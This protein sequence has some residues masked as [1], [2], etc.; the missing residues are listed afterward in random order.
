MKLKSGFT[1]IEITIVLGIIAILFSISSLNLTNSI[2]KNSLNDSMSLLISNIK[3]QQLSAITD[4]NSY[5]IYFGTIKYTLFKG[6]S[7]NANDTGNYDVFLDN[8]NISSSSTGSVIIFLHDTGQIQNLQNPENI[9][10]LVQNNIQQS[11]S[12]TINK[13]GIIE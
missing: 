11:K 8:I 2:P 7:Y 9:I 1:L 5:G 13:Y 4:D 6:D 12:I 3:Q 10:T